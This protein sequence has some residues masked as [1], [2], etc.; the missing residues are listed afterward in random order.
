MTLVS[1]TITERKKP[2]YLLAGLP[3]I[4]HPSY[5]RLVRLV[6]EWQRESRRP[7]A[8]IPRPRLRMLSWQCENLYYRIYG[9]TC[10]FDNV[11]KN[12]LPEKYW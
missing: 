5:D 7:S 6:R 1:E 10:Y 11:P 2:A 12:M 8:I 3:Y 9:H 4:I